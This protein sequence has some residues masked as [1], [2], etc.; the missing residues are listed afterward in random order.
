MISQNRLSL[1]NARAYPVSDARRKRPTLAKN[2]RGLPR[3]ERAGLKKL[4]QKIRASTL[5]VG[6]LTGRSRELAD[7]MDRRKVNTL[8]IQETRW[9]GNRLKELREG[10]KLIYSGANPDSRNG[11]GIILDKVWR[12]DF[13]GVVR[14]NDRIM[15]VKLCAGEM[16]ANV[17]C[18]YAPQVGCT[19]FEKEEF[20]RH[21]G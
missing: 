12:E 8:W 11:V 9:K 19:D 10:C 20:W 4:V 16:N 6:S 21:L 1:E 13:V 17:V 18:A 15:R 2:G 7:L 3:Q 14:R 5:N